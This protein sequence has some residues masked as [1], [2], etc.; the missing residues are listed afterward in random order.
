MGD[1]YE[2]YV[3]GFTP[4]RSSVTICLRGDL[5][6]ELSRLAEELRQAKKHDDERGDA[7]T[8]TAAVI[9]ERIASLEVERNLALRAFAFEGIGEDAWDVLVKKHPP[10]DEQRE[11]GAAWGESF[12][13]EAI[14]LSCV[15]PRMTA[16]Q[17]ADLR[18]RLN[19]GQWHKLWGAVLEANTSDDAG[20]KS[21][22]A[23]YRMNGSA[24]R[25]SSAA[26]TGSPAASS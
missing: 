3:A 9:E 21:P 7:A 25:P 1:T 16:A 14:Q 10:T 17:V 24:T 22:L 26:E 2:D 13:A 4:Q 15:K 8:N 19:R 6:E 20:P 23:S 18:G 11:Q 12:S 5:A